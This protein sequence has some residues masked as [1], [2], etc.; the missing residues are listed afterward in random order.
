MKSRID[1]EQA[2]FHE[3]DGD[4]SGML[5]R[6]ELRA[7]FQKVAHFNAVE[8]TDS[9]LDELVQ[10]ALGED[11]CADFNGFHKTLAKY[12]EDFGPYH[13]WRMLFS[14]WS[15]PLGAGG[16]DD[17]ATQVMKKEQ[18]QELLKE[19]VAL[20]KIERSVS[21]ADAVDIIRSHEEG[22]RDYLRWE[23]FVKIRKD[24]R[25]SELLGFAADKHAG[26]IDTLSPDA[27]FLVWR[28]RQHPA[29]AAAGARAAGG[30]AAPPGVGDDH[31]QVDDDYVLGAAK[32][33]FDRLDTNKN[34]WLETNEVELLIRELLTLQGRKPAMMGRGELSNWAQEMVTHFSSAF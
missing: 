31:M 15:R 17:S 34:G 30:V 21:P 13:A 5:D 8:L 3:V 32:A 9:R 28:L 10:D 26:Y 24:A 23:D 11:V 25:W 20:L 29:A 1:F 16:L 6:S 22:K 4:S 19:L 27:E 2:L 7:L 33:A 18:L 12:P 14:K